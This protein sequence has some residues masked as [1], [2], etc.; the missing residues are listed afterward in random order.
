MAV[1]PVGGWGGT[2]GT[3]WSSLAGSGSCS[4]SRSTA[5]LRSPASR[6]GVV[7]SAGQRQ[8]GGEAAFIRR[9]ARQ[10]FRS[11]R[12]S[13]W[14]SLLSSRSSRPAGGA[15]S[16]P[17]V[18]ALSLPLLSPG[19]P[20][21]PSVRP[22]VYLSTPLVYLGGVPPKFAWKLWILG[23]IGPRFG[24]VGARCTASASWRAAWDCLLVRRSRDVPGTEV[25]GYIGGAKGIGILVAD[26]VLHSAQRLRGTPC[27]LICALFTTLNSRAVVASVTQAAAVTLAAV[28]HA[29]AGPT[30]RRALA[31]LFPAA[32]DRRGK[33]GLLRP[34]AG[35]RRLALRGRARR[36]ERQS[37]IIF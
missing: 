10:F 37:K 16:F 18:S 19:V 25:H 31:G 8:N 21:S 33:L 4:P 5:E 20:L 34:L 28:L 22:R 6:L 2:S 11:G 15:G 35:W 17:L 24:S 29:M 12:W 32:A 36:P 1:T 3:P 30:G 27:T 26:S 13:R 7:V 9:T 23:V 14:P